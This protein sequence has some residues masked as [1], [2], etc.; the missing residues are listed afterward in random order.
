MDGTNLIVCPWALSILA[1]SMLPEDSLTHSPMMNCW[2]PN[3]GNAICFKE[4][5]NALFLG[6]Y[7]NSYCLCACT[8]YEE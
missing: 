1:M 7:F 8:Y 4:H 5:I 2:V 3:G 6:Y